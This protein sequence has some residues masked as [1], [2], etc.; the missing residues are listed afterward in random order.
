L[1]RFG[2]DGDIGSRSWLLLS[3]LINF[4]GFFGDK[5][6]FPIGFLFSLICSGAYVIATSTIFIESFLLPSKY[7]IFYWRF[8]FR[9]SEIRKKVCIVVSRRRIFIRPQEFFP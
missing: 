7:L 1:L 6:S 8:L 2:L 9:Y 5:S 4:S 3:R